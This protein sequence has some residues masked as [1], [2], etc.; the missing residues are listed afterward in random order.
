[1]TELVEV[2]CQGSG[3]KVNLRKSALMPL[4]RK[5]ICPFA[6]E[7]RC[8]KPSDTVKYLDIPFGQQVTKDHI[9]AEL[10]SKV[11]RSFGV[12]A[13]RAR[14]IRGRLLLVHT[15]ILSTLW[16]FT[17]HTSVPKDYIQ[18]WQRMINKFV[19]S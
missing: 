5:A 11:F 13:R 8:M 12:W 3:A 17:P 9:L 2:N 16:H 15:V 19:L 18:R 4:N 6:S 14:T 1:I 10:N 7:V